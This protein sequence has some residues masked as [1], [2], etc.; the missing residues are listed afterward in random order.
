MSRAHQLLNLTGVVPA[1]RRRRCR[2]CSAVGHVRPLAVARAARRHVR[3]LAHGRHA[4]LPPAADA[5]VV[6]DATNGS[7]TSFAAFGLDGGRGP[8]HVLGRRPPQAPRAHRPARATRIRPH[9]HGDGLQ[10]RD[11]RPLVR[12]HGLA[13]RALRP[14]RAP[15][16]RATSTRTAACASSTARSALWV[17]LG[18]TAPVRLGYALS[19]RSAG[20][21]RRRCGAAR[22]GSSCCTT[23]PGRSTP[24]ATSSA[25]AAST[26]DDQST[27]VFWLAP[28]SLGEAWHHN[29]HAFPRSAFHGLQAGRSTPPAASS[30][31]CGRVEARLERRRDLARAPERRS[32]R[33]LNPH[34]PA[35][36]CYNPQ[37]ADGRTQTGDPR[38]AR[39]RR[40]GRRLGAGGQ[41]RRV[42]GHRPPRPARPRR[43]GPAASR[44]RRRARLRAADR[45]VR[46]PARGLARGEGRARRG[47]AAA[48]RRRARDR[49]RRR[50][51]DAGAGPPAPACST[52]ARS[53]PTR[54]RLRRRWRT[55]RRPRSCSSAAGC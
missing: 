23:S 33:T 2:D 4:R 47:G 46:A 36:P 30:A 32:C 15:A 16:T 27:N 37:D 40:Q 50:D 51:D 5:P 10:G 54:R 41:P 14:G 18:V 55:T 7:S 26:V 24:S 20:R 44:S 1:L 3:D 31:G 34:K 6:P 49:P 22:C 8:G 38:A 21:W 13:V 53:S 39:A 9:G 19:A 43:A 35:D 29:H 28:L 42:R 11:R 48:A 12:A 52:T 45:L 25:A 17:A